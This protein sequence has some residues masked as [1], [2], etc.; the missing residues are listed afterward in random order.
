MENRF[1]LNS[2]HYGCGH[3]FRGWERLIPIIPSQILCI[4]DWNEFAYQS[5]GFRMEVEYVSF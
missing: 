4:W 3:L 2:Y 1:Y 5:L